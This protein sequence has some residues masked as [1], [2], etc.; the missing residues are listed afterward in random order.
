MII[1]AIIKQILKQENI[2]QS[3]L[4]RRLGVSRQAVNIMLNNDNMTM[5]T[6]VKMIH[7]VGYDFYIEKRRNNR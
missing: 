5:N 3:E 1:S 6:A 4:A 7:A 2:P